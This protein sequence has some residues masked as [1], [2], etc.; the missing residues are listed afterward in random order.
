MAMTPDGDLERV[1]NR[2]AARTAGAVCTAAALAAVAALVAWIVVWQ[3]RGPA[4]LGYLGVWVA[5]WALM[6]VM[7]VYLMLG[8][9][10]AQRVLLIFWLVVAMTAVIAALAGQVYGSGWWTL[11]VP[12]WTVVVAVLAAAVVCAA[13]LVAASVDRSPLRYASYVTVSVAV[14]VALAIV[15]NVIAQDVYW[16]RDIQQLGRYGLS[17]RT[18]KILANLQ[19]PVRLTCVYTATDESDARGTTSA[20]RCW[21]C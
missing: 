19:V 17:E 21:S 2:P 20:R 6:A 14:A 18:R 16:H 8:R 5:G 9:T 3:G 13:L 15:V 11:P 12:L 4:V 1:L 10:S 7:G